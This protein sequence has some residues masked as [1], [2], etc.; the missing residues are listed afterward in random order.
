MKLTKLLSLILCLILCL[1]LAGAWAEAAEDNAVQVPALKI[2]RREIP[3]NEAMEFLKKMGVGWNLGNTFDATKGDWNR[4]ADEMTVETSWL[5]DKARTTEA[6]FAAL[7]AAGFSAVRIPVSWHDHVDENVQI[8]QKW[9]N[10]VQEV[11]DWALG[12]DLF[13]IL[14]IHHDEDQFLPTPEHY[15][16]SARYVGSI[17]SQLAERFRDYDDRLIFESMNEPRVLGASYEWN[18]DAAIPD[19]VA[20]AKCVNQLNQLF[21][22]TVR[23]SGGHNA[24]RYLM[25]PG[26]D[27]APAGALS[28]VFTLPRDTADNR[29]IVSVHAYT[30]YDFALNTKGGK[31]FGAQSQKMEI[32]S[33]MNSL[34][35]RYIAAG[36]P[37]VIGEYGALTK[38]DDHLQD[39]V[40]WTA[41]Y[42]ATASARNIPCIWWDNGSFSGSGENFGLMNRRN[43]QFVYGEILDAIITYGGWDKLPEAQ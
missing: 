33:F 26:Y 16:E 8:S 17:W 32:V 1:P 2:V 12:Q 11:V 18:Y 31:T 30:P 39:R 43:A 34:Y 37:V 6:M 7:K 35:S 29:I 27:A 42:V 23:A 10:R 3:E 36:I 20:A 22:D 41:F 38:G 25:V 13:V 24:D 15:E 9:L 4:N 14:N 5:P 40:D 21:V 28:D 19:C